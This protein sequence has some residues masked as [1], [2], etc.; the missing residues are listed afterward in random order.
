MERIDPGS[1]VVVHTRGRN[2]ER[3]K[4]ALLAAT[5]RHN[6]LHVITLGANRAQPVCSRDLVPDRVL[7]ERRPGQGGEFLHQ[8]L[9][10]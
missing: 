2:K 3:K 9:L 1:S 10:N 8:Q 6:G 7:C 4:S 5:T